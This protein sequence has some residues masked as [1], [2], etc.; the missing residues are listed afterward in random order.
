MRDVE[1]VPDLRSNLDVLRLDSLQ[2]FV[3]FTGILGYLWLIWTLW[4]QTGGDV[5]A[6]EAVIGSGVMVVSTSTSYA[7]RNRSLRTASVLFIFGT[8]VAVSC[9]LLAF[10]MPDFAY[11]FILPIT[12]AS[13]LFGQ[14]VFLL[15]AIISVFLTSILGLAYL[16]SPVLSI[17][18]PAIITTI[19]T[20]AFWLSARNLRTALAWVLSG[21][22]RA[23]RNEE[24][25]RDR[26][27]KLA[28]ALKALDEATHRVERIN[29]KLALARDQAEEARR[30]KQEFAQT[31]SHELRS[32]L[33]L[34]VGFIELMTE[35]P[36]YYGADIPPA[37]LR[38][39]STVY[40]NACHLQSLVNDV[41]DLARIE[42]AQMSILSEETDPATLAEEATETIRS[43]IES[44]G[45]ALHS[46]IEPDLP[47]LWIDPTR[48]RQVLFNL[49][50]NAMRFTE[51]GNITVSVRLQGEE[52]IFAVADTGVGIASEDQAHI[53][54][55]FRQVDGSTRRRHGGAGLGL[56]I[57]KRFV[58]LH[59]GR[60][61]MES[62]AGEG[63][64]VYFSLPV[65][66]T[67]SV[68]SLTD[69]P[70]ETFRILKRGEEPIL[71][72][73]TRSL[74]AVTLLTR[75]VH[76]CHTVAVSSIA[77]AERSVR[78]LV[79][80]MVV[81]DRMC[82][83]I[84][85]VDLESLAQS[86]GLAHV[87]FI[88]CHLPGEESL[89]QRLTVDGYIIK[90]VSSKIVWDVLRRFGKDAQRIMVIDDDRDFV[91]LLQRILENNPVRDYQ[92]SCAYSV[93]QALL[94][95]QR[96]IPDLVL[97]DLGIPT[98]DDGLQVIEHIQTN[99]AWKHISIVV[100]SARDE[101]DQKQTLVGNVTV[102]KSDGLM[103][104][105]IVNWIQSV[106]DSVVAHPSPA[107]SKAALAPKQVFPGM[108]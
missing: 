78:S 38:D 88:T 47:H 96:Q 73:V 4:P 86:W 15:T 106:M 14:M 29:Y 46:S 22:E 105:E 108:Q 30:L 67:E 20:L 89:R 97:L 50:N 76:G 12:F 48:I 95:M 104:H 71:L 34:I 9:S 101:I 45:L 81:I 91:R 102:A 10:D 7:I 87:P 59:G 57:S 99:D 32:P 62:K 51:E 64:I 41:L 55:E 92:V 13:V 23:R 18:F 74:S 107:T 6:T 40:R 65:R 27:G 33:S 100:V 84:D 26:A 43:L 85:D 37:Y 36:E 53:F 60:I 79:P 8:L 98:L 77:E 80:Q 70:A 58:E 61:W 93:Q 39:L 90:P 44:Q 54:E 75:Y 31:I 69:N 3:L 68:A 24:I 11:L 103:P 28:S 5:P 42:A 83:D 66:K 63:S 21:Y 56:A 72:V 1:H 19:V 25:A 16:E 2:V 82:E 94:K 49:L 35:R 17:V 52:I